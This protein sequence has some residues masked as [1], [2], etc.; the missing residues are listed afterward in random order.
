MSFL[1]RNGL[2]WTEKGYEKQMEDSIRQVDN[3]RTIPMVLENCRVIGVSG[4]PTW[5]M[6]EGETSH[7]EE[8]EGSILVDIEFPDGQTINYYG[9]VYRGIKGVR[10]KVDYDSLGLSQG[11]L[12]R[13]F[14]FDENGDPRTG[15][16][17]YTNWNYTSIQKTGSFVYCLKNKE[18]DF[19]TGK[20]LK[21]VSLY[22][23][24]AIPHMGAIHGHLD[25]NAAEKYKEIF[26]AERY[27]KKNYF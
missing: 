9:R 24:K 1:K 19:L 4:I 21:R 12:Q 18:G 25:K 22:A 7:T 27:M 15:D 14:L 23:D 3:L 20:R 17:H 2:A 26:K 5:D 13:D 11:T 6:I 8:D 10:C 16:L